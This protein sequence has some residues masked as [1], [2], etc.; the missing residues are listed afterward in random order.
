VSDKSPRVEFLADNGIIEIHYFDNPKDKSYR[1]WK[2][3]ESIAN[4]LISWWAR[5]GKKLL[6]PMQIRVKKCEFTMYSE[7]YIEIK[8]VDCQG[9]TNITGWNLPAAAVERLIAWQKI[10]E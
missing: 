8:S 2:L 7:K 3:P 10:A 1:S 6:F 4:E 9:R 5:K